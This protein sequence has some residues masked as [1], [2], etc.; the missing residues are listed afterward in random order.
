MVMIILRHRI[1]Q[2]YTA[3]HHIV[4]SP[5][6]LPSNPSHHI[7]P[8]HVIISSHQITDTPSPVDT[9]QSQSLSEHPSA[10]KVVIVGS[11]PSGLFAAL[12]LAAAGLK[13]IILER[14][15]VQCSA[16]RMC[17]TIL[18]CICNQIH[19][20]ISDITTLLLIHIYP[21]P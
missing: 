1:Y 14:G 11:G 2:Y 5:F 21:Q 16:I 8:S 15:A 18:S 6:S 19:L 12:T 13:P 7:T 10:P 20:S 3:P 17:C 9:T 4:S